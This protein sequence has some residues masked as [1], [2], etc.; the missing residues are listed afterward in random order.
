MQ[1]ALIPK[2]GLHL[3][4]PTHNRATSPEQRGITSRRRRSLE[5]RRRKKRERE[6]EGKA[7][8]RKKKDIDLMRPRCSFSSFF[9]L[10]FSFFFFFFLK[11]NTHP[12]VSNEAPGK[13][14]VG[15]G[16]RE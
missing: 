8:R 14:A 10:S 16:K 15:S 4:H 11:R 7:E 2:L 1:I 13:I 6:R 9:F 3:N 5:E 12:R